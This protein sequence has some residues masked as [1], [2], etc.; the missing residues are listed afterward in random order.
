[1]NSDV[2][3]Y[4]CICTNCAKKY[5]RVSRI[6]AWPGLHVLVKYYAEFDKY[7]KRSS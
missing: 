2:R 6:Y 7:D 1:M 3:N 4:V 5:P